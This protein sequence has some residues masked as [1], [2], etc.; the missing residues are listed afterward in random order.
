MIRRSKGFLVAHAAGTLPGW[1]RPA[2]RIVR[3]LA[4]LGVPLGTI[5]VLTVPGRQ[6][7]VPR[8]TPVS[9]LTVDGHRYVVAALAQSDWARNVRAAGR[10][11]LSQGRRRVPVAIAEVTDPAQREAVMRAFPREVPRGVPM[12]IRLGLVD[13]ADPDQFAA[14]SHVAV[15]QIRSDRPA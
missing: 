10:A 9:P 15:F 6:T 4:R 8:S 5:H 12:L 14:A 2:N 7:G 3:L 13:R 1:L 11:D